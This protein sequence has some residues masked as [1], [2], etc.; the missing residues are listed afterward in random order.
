MF[1]GGYLDVKRG[2][3]NSTG[4]NSIMG[5][6]VISKSSNIVR[7]TEKFLRYEDATNIHG[8]GRYRDLGRNY[9][10]KNFIR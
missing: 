7:I 5:R 3:A 4:W 8:R 10:K 2:S 9:S 6:F 1:Q